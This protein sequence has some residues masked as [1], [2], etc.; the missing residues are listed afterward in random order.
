MFCGMQDRRIV[1][2]L[3]ETGCQLITEFVVCTISYMYHSSCLSYSSLY[4]ILCPSSVVASPQFNHLTS[5]IPIT[6]LEYLL[7]SWQSSPN[8][9]V[10]YSV[11]TFQVPT[12]M[13]L[14]GSL[15]F[16]VCRSSS[17]SLSPVADLS[18]PS[19]RTT[20]GGA[21]V[22]DPGRDRSGILSLFSVLIMAFHGQV[23]TGG[24]RLLSELL[25]QSLVY[26][27]LAIARPPRLG[28]E[29]GIWGTTRSSRFLLKPILFSGLFLFPRVT[30]T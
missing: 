5:L 16:L 23:F 27:L 2:I 4:H 29:V 20:M 10:A 18:L 24:S 21:V 3:L 6:F 17:S 22:V 15:I 8:F 12:V 28:R 7:I 13:P 14:V 11:L 9:P 30:L 1:M 25:H 19:W 26:R